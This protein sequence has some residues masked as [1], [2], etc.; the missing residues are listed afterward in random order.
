MRFNSYTV[1]HGT[2]T[3][4]LRKPQLRIA[5]WL[6]A[7]SIAM[8]GCSRGPARIYPPK[9]DAAAAAAAAV[10]ELDQND[11]QLLSSAELKGCPGLFAE[12]QKHDAN[13]DDQLSADEIKAGLGELSRDGITGLYSLAIRFTLDGGP[14]TGATIELQPEKFLGGAVRPARGKTS[15][16][17][18]ARP[19]TE[20]LAESP[21]PGVQPGARDISPS[22]T[23]PPIK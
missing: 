19:Q 3:H 7:I 14:L 4:S 15:S 20:G 11:D 16:R 18:L 12:R 2:C 6:C 9:V 1:K 13:N 17:G 8:M 10:D 22:G 5:G 21:L 23:L